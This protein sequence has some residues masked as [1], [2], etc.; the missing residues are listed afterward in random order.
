MN[1]SGATHICFYSNRC[2][3]SKAFLTEL[4]QTPYKNNFRFVCV[5]PSPTRQTLPSWLKKVP[6]LVIQGENEPRTDG[7]VMNWIYEEKMK[8]SG[9]SANSN[10]G[11]ATAY[12]GEPEAFMESEMGNNY[13]DPY[14][15]INAE[16]N[17][18]PMTRSFEFLQAPGGGGAM[19]T[20]EASSFQST[21]NNKGRSRKEE[22]FDQQMAQYKAER[23]S[24][25]PQGPRR[26]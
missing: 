6:T 1:K 15:F 21:E 14:T 20:R 24:S 22:L 3:W 10:G 26:M 23:D 18:S 25:A 12:S 9:A 16:A 19:G 13:Q 17:T 4:S 11:G 2:E 8:N 5:D 7:D